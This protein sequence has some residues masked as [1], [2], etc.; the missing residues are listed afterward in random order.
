MGTV[1]LGVN[2]AYHESSVCLLR[3]GVIVGAV[4]EERFN[5]IKHAKCA[6]VDN[7]DVLPDKALE[8]A[9]RHAGI[10][11][12]QVDHIAFSFDPEAR[13]AANSNLDTTGIPAGDYGTPEGEATF[14]RHLH[15]AADELK[16]RFPRAQFHFLPHHICHAGSAFYPSKHE[17]AAVLTIDGIGEFTTTWLGIGE[18]NKLTPVLEI[19]YPNSLG[20]VWEKMSEHLGF[21]IY[22]GPGKLMGYACISDPVGEDTGVDYAERFRQVIKLTD[23]GFTVDNAIMKFRTP[24]FSGLEKLF[25]PRRRTIVDRFEEASIAAGLQTVTEEVFVHL[26]KLLHKKTGLDTLCMAGGVALNCVANARILAETPIRHLHV[27]PAANDAGTAIGAACHLWCH[28]LGNTKRPVLEHTYLGPEYSEQEIKTALDA[29]GLVGEKCDNL[30]A[31]VARMVYDGGVVAWFQGRLEFG[32][33]ALG[34]RSILADP[35]RFDIR[36]RLNAKVKERESFRPFAPSVLAEDVWR[37]LRVPADLDAAEYMLL[38]LPVKEP[39][40]GQRI[41]AVVQEN[42]ITRVATSRAHV[43]RPEVNPIYARLL[44]EMR[45][46]S[47]LGMILNTSFNISEPIVCSPAD[48]ISCFKRSKMDALAIGPFLVKR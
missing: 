10:T 42:G 27:Q 24:D 17:K 1:I 5:R 7:P 22:G 28:I 39:R 11:P 48:A 6:R 18:G 32:P 21:D 15:L 20:F 30:P 40:D 38:A 8:W 25:G 33:R 16:R 47:G 3:D 44:Q 23:T 29:A 41:P 36:S 14:H 13:L 37:H 2:S 12:D 46:L 19:P 43:V 35:S 45:S 4:E 34:N 9:L 31:R 26:A